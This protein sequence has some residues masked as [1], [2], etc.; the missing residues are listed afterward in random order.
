[1]P[2]V[3]FTGPLPTRNITVQQI[4]DQCALH[5]K[6]QNFFNVGGITFEPGLTIANDTNQQLLAR[7]FAWK[8]NREELSGG[9]AGNG[10]F[11][12]TQFGVQDYLFAGACAFVLFQNTNT[13]GTTTTAQLGG[14]V[15]IDLSA[16]PINGG[17]AGI[18]VNVGTG[19]VTVQ[20]LQ[21]HPFV[22]GQTV[23]MTGNDVA[24]YNSIWTFQPQAQTSSWTQGWV[25]TAVPDNLH[26]QFQATAGQSVSSGAAGIFNWGWGE[27]AYL[28]D[29]NSNSFPQPTFKIE[30]VDRLTTSYLCNDPAQIAMMQDL[31]NGV[32]KFRLD[33]CN[34]PYC[35]MMNVVYQA[36]AAKLINPQS[37]FQWPDNLS[38]VLKEVALAQAFRFATGLSSD[39]TKTQ[40]LLAQ[41]AIASA[42]GSDDRE[43]STEGFAPRNFHR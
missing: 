9:P 3:P 41:Q 23:F 10:N 29:I 21:Q 43:S 39:D 37:I 13:S 25:I 42:L 14:G 33:N 12:V 6:L 31:N 5:T 27:S 36:R 4:I 35:W 17:T 7:P 15:G 40:I 11:F 38:F 19:V 1:M 30:M 34:G 20:T 8:F 16:N 32:L 26:F 2:V 18:T 24:A 22:V 28:F